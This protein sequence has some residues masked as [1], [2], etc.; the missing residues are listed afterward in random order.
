MTGVDEA[1]S[2]QELAARFR[3][4]RVALVHDWL[5]GMRG[6]EKVLEALLPLFPG[7]DILT[8][9]Y[10]PG[11]V[12]PAIR[13]RN[14]IEC[15]AARRFPPLRRHYRKALPLLPRLAESLPT[16]DYDLVLATSHCVAKGVRPPRRG[17]LLAYVFTPM[18]YVWDQFDEYLGGGVFQDAALRYFRPRMQAWDRRTGWRP[19]AIAADSA[20]V[21]ERIARHWQRKARV[22]HPGIDQDF[23]RPGTGARGKAYLVVSAL[24]P[25][26]RIDLAID[27]A[28]RAGVPLVIIGD[29]PE[30]GRLRAMAGPGIEFR[31]WVGDAEVRDAYRSARALL[32]PGV[33]DYGLTA[34]EAQACGTPVIAY[35]AGGARETIVAGKGGEF[36]PEQSSASLARVLT[37]FDPD[38]YSPPCVRSSVA[39]FTTEHF[40]RELACWIL[41]ETTLAP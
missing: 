15:S 24:A 21:A 12:S 10:E 16:T 31:G 40:Q 23:F 32:Y 33:E 9:F 3:T 39:P 26:K 18:R 36:F 22:I 7:A 20:F 17:H 11:K 25:Y 13:S 14:V 37:A 28:N 41:E 2:V 34:V 4:A 38:K 6:G 30:R 29:G 19:D 8:L 1:N 5:N 27:A 35:A